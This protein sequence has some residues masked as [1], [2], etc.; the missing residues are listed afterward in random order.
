[1]KLS[2]SQFVVSQCPRCGRSSEEAR[3]LEPLWLL[4]TLV[5]GKAALYPVPSTHNL[6]SGSS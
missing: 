4:K 2:T 6:G 3:G 5:A 1:M